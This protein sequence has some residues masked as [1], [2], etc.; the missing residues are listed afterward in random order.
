MRQY[1]AGFGGGGWIDRHA[2]FIDVLNDSL[3]VDD[4][5]GS[6]AEAL[7]FIKDSIILHHSSLEI[8]EQWKRYANVLCK[9]TIGRNAIDADAEDLSFCSFEFGDIS[10]IRLEFFRSTAGEGQHIEGQ[11]HIFLSPEIA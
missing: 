9:T 1:V 11:H 8:T 10:L 2:A 5:C 3:L 6:I 7:F 4:E